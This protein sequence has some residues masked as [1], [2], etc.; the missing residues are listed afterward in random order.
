MI[1][2]ITAF[3]LLLASSAGAMAAPFCL[4]LPS[5]APQCVY[6]DGAA[7]A[8]E[9]GRQNGSCQVNAAEVRVPVS[10]VGQYCLVMPSG[11]STCGY[12]DGTLCARDAL[13]QK[14]ACERSGGAL[15]R[16]LPDDYAPNAGR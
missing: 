9:A 1:K 5:G 2:V 6:Y 14:G 11:Y 16:Q 15:P 8:R 7:C 12:A 3:T 4:A 13:L 10:R